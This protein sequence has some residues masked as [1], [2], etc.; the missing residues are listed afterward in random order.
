MAH[1][2]SFI[3]DSSAI[4]AAA[5]HTF[6]TVGPSYVNIYAKGIY[7]V[8]GKMEPLATCGRR[9]DKRPNDDEIC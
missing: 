6:L 3:V 7:P 1:C 2:T 8:N 9:E 4:P 5:M